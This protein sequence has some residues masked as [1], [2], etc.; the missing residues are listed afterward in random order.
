MKLWISLIL[1][2]Y[3]WIFISLLDHESIKNS[4]NICT[5]NLILNL[6]KN[7]ELVWIASWN[8]PNLF[9][10]FWIFSNLSKSL[11]LSESF[12]SCLYIS[13]FMTNH[14]KSFQITFWIFPNHSESIIIQIISESLRIFQISLNLSDFSKSFP[15]IV[16]NLSEIFLGL[17]WLPAIYI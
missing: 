3:F 6:L 2:E 7:C 17:F 10:T 1:S 5:W 16:L 14:S 8:L 15:I 4:L 11:N 12:L 9:K 13:E